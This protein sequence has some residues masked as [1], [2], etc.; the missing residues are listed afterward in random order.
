MIRS[1]F[2][3]SEN[4]FSLREIE[5]LD[6]QQEIYDTLQVHSQQGGL[7]LIVGRPGTGKS[8]IKEVS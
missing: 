6:H 3:L 8:V 2:G 5:L 7:C 4:P 1:Y